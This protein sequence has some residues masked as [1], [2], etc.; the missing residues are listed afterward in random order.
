VYR[1]EFMIGEILG[2]YRLTQKL[3]EGGVGETY[4]GEHLETG[5]KVAVKVLFP[6]M[7]TDRALLD[8]FFEE[9]RAA[10][11]VNHVG[12][13]DLVE[14]GVHPGGRA[15]LIMEYLVGKT[16]TDALIELG[17]VNDIESLADIAWQ[18]ATML[19]AAHENKILHKAL[20]PDGIYLTFPAEQSPR[21]LVKLVDFGM[22]K[23]TLNVRQ[24]QTGS[25]LGAPL[26]MAPE[27]G[28]GTTVDHRADIYS[29]GC[30]MFEMACGRPPFIREGRGELLIAHATEP[31]PYVSS[32]EP[33]I[34][35]AIDKLIGG[36]LTKNPAARPQTMADVALV[37][38]RFFNC[39]MSVA[40]QEVTAPHP[41]VPQPVP[42]PEVVAPP[43]ELP[44]PAGN[45][46][47]PAKS[48]SARPTPTSGVAKTSPIIEVSRTG[49]A[50][51]GLA[52]S[53]G[54]QAVPRPLSS[55]GSAAPG[56]P[57]GVIRSQAPTVRFSDGENP[58]LPDPSLKQS[59]IARVRQKTP[60]FDRPSRASKPRHAGEERTRPSRG[61]SNQP[62][63]KDTQPI[64]MPIVV[65]SA[66]L[67]VVLAALIYLMISRRDG[68]KLQHQRPLNPEIEE[69]I[70][71]VE[72]AKPVEPHPT[73]EVEARPSSDMFPG[74]TRRKPSTKPKGVG[75][76]SWNPVS[77]PSSTEP[78]ASSGKIWE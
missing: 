55:D 54:A 19:R 43:P 78:S 76:K 34:P 38:E 26:Y 52:A 41:V 53:G 13:A 71:K 27:I 47:V 12:I 70:P 61:R 15:Y 57:D 7:C 10:S 31:A 51:A 14:C 5:Y 50:W 59:W 17:S 46:A 2:G 9:T 67:L 72:F 75:T 28:R 68:G 42:R 20:K 77:T 3:G 62:V 56:Q 45:Q 39:P 25:L 35:P 4:L 64:S 8:R 6:P 1:Q 73:H 49:D 44:Q 33:S 36:M 32:L 40:K 48:I 69:P 60:V 66:S 58:A 63:G 30:I 16:L 24:S 21:P 29:L 65:V 37:L 74:D 22:A 18:L 11:L 23:F